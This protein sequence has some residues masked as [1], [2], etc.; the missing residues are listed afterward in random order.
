M[1]SLLITIAFAVCLSTALSAQP[2]IQYSQADHDD[3]N[4]YQPLVPGSAWAA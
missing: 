4:V 1:K 3:T 2:P